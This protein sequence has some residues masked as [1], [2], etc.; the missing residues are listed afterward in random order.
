MKNIG[1]IMI[2]VGALILVL[3][4]AADK[5]L[6]MGTVDQNWIQILALLL[7]IAGVPTHIHVV[8]KDSKA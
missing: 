3:S 5:F 2:V 4:Y 8:G 7:I 1:I 6:N